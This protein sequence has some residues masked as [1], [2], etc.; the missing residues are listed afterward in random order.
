MAALVGNLLQLKS[1]EKER[2][3]DAFWRRYCDGV[4]ARKI[5]K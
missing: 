2:R 4:A 5:E 1:Q 3:L